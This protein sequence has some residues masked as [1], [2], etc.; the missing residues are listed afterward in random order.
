MITAERQATRSALVS[1]RYQLLLAAEKPRLDSQTA[2]GLRMA[3][4]LI[5]RN[6]IEALDTGDLLG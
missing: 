1:A 5:Q 3:A 4:H 2:R 6:L